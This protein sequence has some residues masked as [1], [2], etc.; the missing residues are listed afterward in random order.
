VLLQNFL[1]PAETIGIERVFHQEQVVAVEN[2]QESLAPVVAAV[3]YHARCRNRGFEMLIRIFLLSCVAVT[4]VARAGDMRPDDVA[5]LPAPPP[6]LISSYG[7]DPLQFGE[8]RLPGGSGPFPVVVVIHG[9]C[10]TKGFATVDYTDALA[11]E[12]TG[13]GYA[14]WNIEYRQL[15][16]PGAGWPGT[17]RDWSDAVDHLRELAESQPLSLQQVVVIG[18]SAGAHAA[19]WLGSRANLHDVEYLT[20]ESPLRPQAVIAIDGIADLRARIGVDAEICGKPVLVPL[21]GGTPGEVPE[22]FAMASPIESLPFGVHQY[23]VASKNMTPDMA[24]A[25]ADLARAGG[26]EV[27]VL[28]VVGGG[29][30]D[31][32]AP[33]TDVWKEQVWPFLEKVLRREAR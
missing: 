10:W 24:S 23:L 5:A 6:D 16:D 30:H 31:I 25:Y 4:A 11:A 12:I 15:G 2:I 33:T 18:H 22:R 3:R 7:D 21:L 9:G 27:E 20:G 13:L 32:M 26:D 14:T 8:L 29:H 1:C 28:Q 19:L 17:F